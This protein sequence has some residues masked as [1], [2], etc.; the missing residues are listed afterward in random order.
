MSRPYIKL[1]N[2]FVITADSY[3]WITGEEKDYK[4]GEREGE[5]YIN[6]NTKRFHSNLF[7]ALK[8]I[9]D[10]HLRESEAESLQELILEVANLYESMDRLRNAINN[11]EIEV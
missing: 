6:P 2:G 3:Q 7:S 11:D 9:S 8:Y 5:T 1:E 10:Q 4:S